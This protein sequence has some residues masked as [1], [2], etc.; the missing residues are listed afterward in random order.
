LL[1]V[2]VVL[3]KVAVVLVVIEPHQVFQF[4]PVHL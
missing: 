1:A 2:V 3:L 4:Q